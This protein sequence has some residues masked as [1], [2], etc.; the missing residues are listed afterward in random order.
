MRETSG[1][2][3]A[4]RAEGTLL[5]SL[6]IQDL[7]NVTYEPELEVWRFSCGLRLSDE[8]VLSSSSYGHGW[9]RAS[10]NAHAN[11]H[12]HNNG[13]ERYW[14]LLETVERGGNWYKVTV[15]CDCTS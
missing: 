1:M 10:V 15:S 7:C 12:E 3:R 9:V 2:G 8:V 4:I 14:E 5:A 13:L 11:H 6:I